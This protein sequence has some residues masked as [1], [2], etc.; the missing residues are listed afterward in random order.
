MILQR[1]LKNDQ[2]VS[3]G[4]CIRTGVEQKMLSG[5]LLYGEKK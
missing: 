3:A 1:V 4:V 5:I 2:E